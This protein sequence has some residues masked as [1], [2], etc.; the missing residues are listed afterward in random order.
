[1]PP[2]TLPPTVLSID[3]DD[4]P[5]TTTALG[6]ADMSD[7]N[8]FDLAARVV[9]QPKRDAA[10]SFVLHAPLELAARRL[11]LPLVAPRYRRAVR[12]RIL[13]VAAAYERAG[14]PADSPSLTNFDSFE[15]ARTELRKRS[16][17]ATSSRSTPR[18]PGSSEAA[19]F[20][21][22]MTLAGPTLD[23]LGA[24]G[25]ASI[26]FFLTSRL[27]DTSRSS[28]RLLRP[29]LRELARE[30]DLRLDWIHR[31]TPPK[32]DEQQ[33]ATALAKT[34][35]LGIPGSDFI[36]PIVHQVDR[37]GVARELIESTLPSDARRAE[38]AILRVAAR[39]MLQDDSAFAPYGWT[40]CL[41]LPQA[42]L[43]IRGLASG[44]GPSGCG[45]S[46]LCRGIP[47]GGGSGCRST[48]TGHPNPPPSSCSPP[49]TR[50]PRSRRAWYHADD[51]AIAQALPELVGRAAM[52]ADA[53][54]AKYTYVVPRRS[55]DRCRAA[56]ALPSCRGIPRRMVVRT[57]MTTECR[58]LLISGSLRRHSTNT[59]VLRTA[60]AAAP[61]G[62]EAKL[63]EGLG[64]LPP[65]NPD[66]DGEVLPEA[67]AQLRTEVRA[68]DALGPFDARVR[69]IAPRLVQ[70]P[71]G[72]V[73]RRRPGR[74]PRRQAGLL[75]QSVDPGRAPRVSVAAHRAHVRE[76]S[77]R[78]GR[79]R[80]RAADRPV[81]GRGRSGCGSRGCGPPVRGRG[82]PRAHVLH[83]LRSRGMT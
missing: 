47:G 36:Y 49:S 23:L 22:I 71:V 5:R 56:C 83:E 10:D 40:H 11:L 18:R 76:R 46:D 17:S 7:A 63:Y 21:Q 2:E 38:R 16:G 41:T 70:E 54:L 57:A 34:P 15:A 45:R 52:H 37:S 73:D 51:E 27:A 69:R 55:P 61:P 74:I 29:T 28:L 50:D 30:A 80:G 66:D 62:V 19:T 82:H 43:H 20:D 77:G 8:L 12:Q 32:G 39:S 48:S 65:F 60:R 68:A 67:V 3:P 25:H 26:V 33:F 13:T 58:L 4:V 79:V 35:R 14:E 53:H 72:L 24:A 6:F 42:V 31:S 9:A 78:R 81:A 64:E 1:M 59:A 44:R 75:G